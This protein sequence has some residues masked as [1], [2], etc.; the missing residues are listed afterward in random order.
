MLRKE[1][2]NSL[3]KCMLSSTV[4][5]ESEKDCF[6]KWVKLSLRISEPVSISHSEIFNSIIDKH[7][8]MQFFTFNT[9]LVKI[10]T[11]RCTFKYFNIDHHFK[12]ILC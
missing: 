2:V 4:C 1:I 12:L 11:C 3:V 6:V 7:E 9:I 10:K 5:L 8:H